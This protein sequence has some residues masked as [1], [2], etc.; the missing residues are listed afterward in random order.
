M[1]V[2]GARSCPSGRTL[3][4]EQTKLMIAPTGPISDPQNFACV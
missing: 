1:D 2:S 3:P 4:I